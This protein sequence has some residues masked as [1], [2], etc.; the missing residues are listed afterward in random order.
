LNYKAN[1]TNNKLIKSTEL[2]QIPQKSLIKDEIVQKNANKS[3]IFSNS[4]FKIID[5]DVALWL[6]DVKCDEEGNYN[7]KLSGT[8][9]YMAPELFSKMEF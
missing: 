1:I 2:K 6:D 8:P 3:E 7:I 4:I 9:R 5:F